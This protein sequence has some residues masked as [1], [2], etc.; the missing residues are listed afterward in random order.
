[1]ELAESWIEAAAAPFNN[2]RQSELT[3]PYLEPALRALPVLKRTRKIFFVNNWLAAFIGGQ[4]DERAARVVRDFLAREPSLD[5]D[6]RLKVL[7]AA[8]GLERCVRIRARHATN[9]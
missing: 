8:D 5:R 4:C 9:P 2:P 7:E 1:K 6:L 3:L